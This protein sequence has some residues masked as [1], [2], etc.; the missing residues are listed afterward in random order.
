MHRAGWEVVVLAPN[1]EATAFDSAQPFKT[2]RAI[3][4][5]RSQTVLGKLGLIFKLLVFPIRMQYLVNKYHVSYVL[6]TGIMDLR[7][8][9]G[10]LRALALGLLKAPKGV[11][12][13]GSDVVSIPK[14]SPI[15]RLL[16]N[17]FVGSVDD[18]FCNSHFTAQEFKKVF[19]Q[20]LT[21]EV[22]GCGVDSGTLPPAVDKKIAKEKL[23]IDADFVLLTIGRLIPRKGI[24]MVIK[25]LPDILR[26][27]PRT[28]YLVAG[29]GPDLD[30]LKDL[31]RKVGCEEHV[32]FDGEFDNKLLGHYYCV[33]DIFVMPSRYIPNECVEGFGIVYVEAGYYGIPVI[34]GKA[35]GVPDAVVDGETGFLVNPEDPQEIGQAILRLLKDSSLRSKMGAAGHR[36]AVNDLTWDEVCRP[37]QDKI[38]AATREASPG[39]LRDVK[40]A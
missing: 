40:N 32:R 17:H 22:I 15:R 35:G 18:V 23:Q 9:S 5:F 11:I 29:A 2:I 26:S 37:I 13:H 31:G 19:N 30:R 34:G 24:D 16:Y 4:L 20:K 1:L 12:C 25:A 39:I 27:F 7:Y 10:F 14:L 3:P 28:V 8:N 36:R 33:A 6:I 21:P 38:M